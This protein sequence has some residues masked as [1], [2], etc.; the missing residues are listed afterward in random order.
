MA[1][2]KN[3]ADLRD[4]LVSAPL[5]LTLESIYSKNSDSPIA[6]GKSTAEQYAELVEALSKILATH[7]GK[8][9][10]NDVRDLPL[11]S[12]YSLSEMVIV[13]L[14]R[15][16]DM[17]L[18]VMTPD[19][20]KDFLATHSMNVAFLSCAVGIG[21]GLT[22]KELTELGVASFLHDI[23][24]TKI[25][26]HLYDSHE[27]LSK[28]DRLV[29][30]EHP[31][32][33]AMML[34]KLK[35]EF[36]WLVRV[37]FE[38]H[39]REQGKGYPESVKGELHP[40]S[41]IV[42]L[43]DSYEALTHHRK[44]RKA[45]HPSDVIKAIMAAKGTLFSQE[46]IR[47]MIESLSMFPVGSIV[48]LNNKKSALVVEPVWRSPLRPIIRIIHENDFEPAETVNLS[49]ENNLYIVGIVYSDDYQLPGSLVLQ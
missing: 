1:T 42:G 44:Y 48:E 6:T 39:K 36:P 21:I 14:S 20:L 9:P 3:L 18:Q 24:M 29:V 28:A 37:I 12:I 7:F 38:E 47:I 22:F 35:T 27:L 17:L 4:T 43:C 45:F 30:E 32:I 5:L 46:T 40:Y 10:I 19:Y 33:G 49:K 11:T 16:P 26:A 15:S 25:E 31:K 41:K 34:D 8:I 23:G 2:I 13:A